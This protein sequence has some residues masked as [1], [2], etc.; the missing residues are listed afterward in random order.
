MKE[1]CLSS[2]LSLLLISSGTTAKDFFNLPDISLQSILF[3]IINLYN[4]TWKRSGRNGNM[5]IHSYPYI[6]S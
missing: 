4:E 2:T 5:V 6:P 1:V 3:S